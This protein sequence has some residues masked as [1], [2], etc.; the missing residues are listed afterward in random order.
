MTELYVS[1]ITQMIAHE[2]F[3]SRMQAGV[4]RELHPRLVP[5]ALMKGVTVV[6]AAPS[7]EKTEPTL[8]VEQ[9]VQAI[10]QLMQDGDEK[11]FAVTGEPKLQPLKKLLGAPVS[12]AL[13]DAAW[14]LVKK[15]A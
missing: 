5:V 1:P 14:E 10:R 8:T 3:A 9:V 12:D 11:A 13:R 7:V 15:E 4:S 6:G 2:G